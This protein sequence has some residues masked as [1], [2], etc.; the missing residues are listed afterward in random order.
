MTYT[1]IKDYK[2]LVLDNYSKLYD[3]CENNKLKE[4]YLDDL[5]KIESLLNKINPSLMFYG[6]Y[7]SGKSTLLN[8]IFGELKASV[9]DIPETHKVTYY[10]WK[11][12]DLVDTP[13][14]NGPLKDFKISKLELEKHDII[15]FVIDDSDSF[16]SMFVAE[17]IV[18]IIS[19]KKP[20]IIVLNE[21]QSEDEKVVN[22]IRNKLYQNVKVQANKRGLHNVE[23]KYE[24]ISINAKLAFIGKSKQKEAFIK[25][26]NI[27]NL[28]ILISRHLK[29]IDEIKMLK[30]PIRLIKNL[31]DNIISK[32]DEEL[33]NIDKNKSSELSSKLNDIK[34]EILT[35]SQ[36]NIRSQIRRYNELIYNNVISGNDISTLQKDLADKI[37]E[38]FV[39]E[40]NQFA[41]D[42]DI[43]LDNYNKDIRL[44][45]KLNK[46]NPEKSSLNEYSNSYNIKD[47]A[48]SGG[49][50]IKPFTNMVDISK[51]IKFPIPEPII[52]VVIEKIIGKLFDNKR[53]RE[54]RERLIEEVE[55]Q[56]AIQMQEFNNK[57]NYMQEARSQINI[58]LYEFEEK[59][60]EILNT[61][62]EKIYKLQQGYIDELKKRNTEEVNKMIEFKN[63]LNSIKTNVD[64]VEREISFGR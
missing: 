51:S 53:E 5:N 25:K 23:Q 13:G 62:I 50:D 12:F 58:N 14:V 63:M 52:V 45:F 33:K 35:E 55:R 15:M 41:S 32:T 48:Q 56:N 20:L 6:V 42:L 9:A 39:R 29:E 26:S 10:R 22:D 40:L 43:T 57:I 44:D 31:I 47:N 28:E 3:I 59:V 7:N 21:K 4:L 8:A 19:N 37:N 46:Y 61:E 1:K 38:I 17:E 36:L 34:N 11:N 54:K 30:N 60:M 24:F 27:S 64:E 18:D 16:D 49:L 2:A